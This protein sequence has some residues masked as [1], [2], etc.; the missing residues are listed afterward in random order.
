MACSQSRPPTHSVTNTRGV[1]KAVTTAAT[2]IW[3]CPA[4]RARKASCA[5]ASWA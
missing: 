2:L 3:G 4:Q 5:Q 1:D